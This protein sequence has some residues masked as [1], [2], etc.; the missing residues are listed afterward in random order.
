MGINGGSQSENRDQ[1]SNGSHGNAKRCTHAKCPLRRELVSPR[2]L[3]RMQLVRNEGRRRR[4][5]TCTLELCLA[6]IAHPQELTHGRSQPFIVLQWRF[7]EASLFRRRAS[8]A[9]SANSQFRN[10]AIF[11]T[12]EVTFGQTI[13]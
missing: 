5:G 4:S 7:Y 8:S 1:Q 10:I 11:G 2:D 6:D 12:R 3:N 13:Q 9:A